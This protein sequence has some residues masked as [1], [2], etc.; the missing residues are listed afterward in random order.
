MAFRIP[1][2]RRSD[3]SRRRGPLNRLRLDSR[4]RDRIRQFQRTQRTNPSEDITARYNQAGADVQKLNVHD[5]NPV[6]PKTET[7]PIKAHFNNVK[8]DP[9]LV[10]ASYV[11]GSQMSSPHGNRVLRNIDAERA[12]NPRWREFERGMRNEET[13]YR[14][15]GVRHKFVMEGLEPR[16]TGKELIR[17]ARLPTM[18]REHRIISQMG[19][20]TVNRDIL[21]RLK[22]H[23]QNL[24][25]VAE[26]YS[27]TPMDVVR[28]ERLALKAAQPA[29]GKQAR[30]LDG[31]LDLKK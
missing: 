3:G 23:K 9:L 24:M 5:M 2:F 14:V 25:D 20:A 6:T 17:E 19:D 30:T 16:V 13:R 12:R 1:R 15:T 8:R 4:V 29:T 28:R 26:A 7:N 31:L 11:P 27:L 22:V 18:S 21:Q 10:D